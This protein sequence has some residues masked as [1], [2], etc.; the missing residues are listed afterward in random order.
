MYS[1]LFRDFVKSKAIPRSELED[2]LRLPPSRSVKYLYQCAACENYFS[3]RAMDID[4]ITPLSTV[5]PEE[6]FIFWCKEIIDLLLRPHNLQMLCKSC[7]SLKT[8]GKS[9]EHGTKAV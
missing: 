3:R 4:H 9:A 6:H 5:D 1:Q 7:H 2:K 8:K